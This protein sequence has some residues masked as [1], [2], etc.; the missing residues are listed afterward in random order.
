MALSAMINRLTATTAT[1]LF[2][3]YAILN[4]LTLASI[5]VV[6]TGGSIASTFFITAGTFGAMSAYGYV[7]K[8]DL[9]RWGNLLLMALIGL[10][11]ASVV[12]LFMHSETLYW[13]SSFVG[14]LIFTGL[15]A[16]DTQKIKAMNSIGNAG[17]DED[18]SLIHI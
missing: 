10:I 5:F 2:L 16:Y 15:T 3:V 1:A 12:N 14:V 18:L 9:T 11:I 6:F 7:T 13:I 17:T 8:S 4:G